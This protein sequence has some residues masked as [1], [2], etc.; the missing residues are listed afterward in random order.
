M[1]DVG[2]KAPDFTLVGWHNGE[3]QEYTLS[4][5]TATGAVILGVYVF[6]FSPVC[7]AQM[8]QTGDMNWYQYK[9]DLSLFGLSRDG[10][11]S[12]EKF[13]QQE[14]IEYPLL[15]DVSGEVLDAY[16]LLI[17]E[18]DGIREVPRRAL[19]LIDS[20]RT[21][22]YFWRAADNW[23]THDYGLNPVREAIKAL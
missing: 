10:P 12:H 2:D 8:C 3:T 18:V 1:V 23:D 7:T 19:L 4:D 15:S 20:E 16:D 22:R 17:P 5:Y 9:K 14:G 13:S 11:Y 6:D 21:I